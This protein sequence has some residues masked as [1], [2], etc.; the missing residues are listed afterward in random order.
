MRHW[1]S[2][3]C[4]LLLSCG[5]SQKPVQR[6]A[7]PSALI[8]RGL[9]FTGGEGVRVEVI[10]LNTGNT[11][12]IRVTGTRTEVEGKVLEHRIIDDGGRMNYATSIHG[13]D[14][15][16]LVREAS[17]HGGNPTWQL[18]VRGSDIS[19]MQLAYDEEASKKLDT[20]ALYRTH[21]DQRDGGGL[22]ALQRFDRKR[23]QE[24]HEAELAKTQA[25][26]KQACGA[27]VAVTIDWSTV[28]DDL[29][30]ELSI[31]G[32]CEP[33]LDA[34]R[35]L[36]EHEPARAFFAQSV[37]RYQC[38]F[39]GETK[40]T[41]AD[42]TMTW[43]VS[44]E[45]SNMADFA[46]DALLAQ[47]HGGQ[48]LR[49]QIALASTKVCA[50]EKSS[51]YVVFAA[52]GSEQPGM[53]YGDGKTLRQ[54]RHPDMMSAGWFFEPRYF[55]PQ[56]NDNFRGLDLRHFS[57]VEVEDKE[58]SCTLTCGTHQ[59]KLPLLPADKAAA[60][61]ASAKVEPAA[62]PRVPHALARDRQGIYYYV[63]RS[64]EPGRERDFQLYV[65]PLGNVKRQAMKNVVSDSE[66]E[67]FSSSAGD[68]RF[69]L[70]RDEA[71]WI[72][73]KQER[74][75]L[76]VPI[77]ENWQMIYNKLGVYFGVSLGNPCDDY[78]DK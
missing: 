21:E 44:R 67:I 56:H 63:D 31:S 7:D 64:T 53:L 74:K 54:V 46:R 60:L 10:E 22:E 45:G 36:C 72:T 16:T 42:Q 47:T 28:D 5:S 25:S 4:L 9:V 55:N 69:I 75:L 2:I 68:L 73:G 33:A 59:T 71:Q 35:Y 77:E 52:D 51:R 66:G 27:D 62:M 19:G 23:E 37:K 3:V 78:G 48:T 13:R 8:A 49:Q 29:L 20:V 26:T 18:Y 14:Q 1:L 41:I 30:K 70:G 24:R 39:G 65:G 58:P 57:F 38:R 50:D 61:L 34:M 15:Y 40:L 32:Y 76:K 6:V 17:R 43:A 11:A 12:L